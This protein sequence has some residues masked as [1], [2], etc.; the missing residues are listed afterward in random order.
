MSSTLD[1]MYVNSAV[2]QRALDLDNVRR[3]LQGQR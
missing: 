1:K 2:V 3:L